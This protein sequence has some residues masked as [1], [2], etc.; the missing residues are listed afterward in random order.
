MKLEERYFLVN[1]VVNLHVIHIYSTSYKLNLI[2][3]QVGHIAHEYE[4]VIS[5]MME[6]GKKIVDI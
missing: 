2:Y 4:H 1:L 5:F 3:F 6:L